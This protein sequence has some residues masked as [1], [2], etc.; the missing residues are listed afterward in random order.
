[1]D[2]KSDAR[3]KSTP[4]ISPLGLTINVDL[5]VANCGPATAITV[6]ILLF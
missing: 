6:A 4:C 2:L 5:K 1:M 3:I